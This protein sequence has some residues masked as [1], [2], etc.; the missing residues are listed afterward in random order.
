MTCII[1]IRNFNRDMGV[2]YEDNKLGRL[3]FTR[4]R[5]IIKESRRKTNKKKEKVMKNEETKRNKK[6]VNY[7]VISLIGFNLFT[8]V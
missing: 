8:V 7:G 4:G 3:R 6:T 2:F 1:F 5:T